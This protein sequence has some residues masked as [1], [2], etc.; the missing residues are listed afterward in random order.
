MEVDS[1]KE[2]F[3]A[4]EEKYGVKYL[5][6]IGD[7]DSKTFN[8]ILK[9]NPY[10]D[11]NPVTKNECIGH[12]AK[13]MGTRLRNVKKHHKLGG[14]GKLIEGLIKK[15]SLYYGLAIRRNIN[16][17]EDMK[18]AILAT[19][20]HMISTDEN[21]RHEY[22]PLGVDSWCKWNKAEASGIDPSSLKHPA[23]MH[24]DIQEHV[25]PIF[26]NLSNDDLLQRCLGGHTQNANESFN[27]TIW[28][29]A[30]KHLNSGLKITEI[31]AYLAAGIFNE[32]FSSILRVMQQL[33]LTIGTYCMSFANK[34]DEIR[35][36]QEEHRSH[37]A[38]KKARKARTDRLLTQ[39]ALFEEA[40]GLLYGAGIAD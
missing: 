30:P 22:C 11:D 37:S 24:K 21:P 15:I 36:S 4:S 16:S 29:I 32:G 19:Y 3:L 9:E 33:E 7:G 12:V 26:E 28:R 18:N 31:A 2:M 25:F 35:V 40:E 39:N 10:G 23:P 17:V 5:N 14:R 20:Y 8:A 1:I 13:R 34:R 6:Y 27:A 38:S